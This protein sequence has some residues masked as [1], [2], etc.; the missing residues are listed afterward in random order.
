M[1]EKYQNLLYKFYAYTCTPVGFL[2]TGLNL[3]LFNDG[4][5]GNE[6]PL[7]TAISIGTLI[8]GIHYYH[9]VKNLEDKLKKD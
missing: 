8:A 4:V 7:F 6:Q 1:N 2:G 9:K 3:Y 5:Q